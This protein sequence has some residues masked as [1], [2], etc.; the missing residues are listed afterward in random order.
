MTALAIRSSTGRPVDRYRQN[1]DRLR[2][3]GEVVRH[4]DIDLADGAGDYQVF[5]DLEPSSGNGSPWSSRAP[6]RRR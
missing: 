2:A 6:A 5:S 1:A 4:F 3:G